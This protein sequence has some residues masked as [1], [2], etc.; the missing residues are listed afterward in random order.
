MFY[1]FPFSSIRKLSVQILQEIIED[2]NNR[3][4]TDTRGLVIEPVNSNFIGT[5]PIVFTERSAMQL[6]LH[7]H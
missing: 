3:K 7:I 6:R 4:Y 5:I 2:R 1:A